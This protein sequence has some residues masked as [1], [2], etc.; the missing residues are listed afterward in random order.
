MKRP[1]IIREIRQRGGWTQNEFARLIGTTQ[2]EVSL[3]ET[4]QAVP[5][6][7]YLQ[8]IVRCTGTSA[9]KILEQLPAAAI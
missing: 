9:D 2:T 5:S 3:W 6:T 4:G 1:N 8:K 7:P